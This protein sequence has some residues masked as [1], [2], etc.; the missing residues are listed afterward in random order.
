MSSNL[1]FTRGKNNVSNLI[2]YHSRLDTEWLSTRCL[3]KLRQIHALSIFINPHVPNFPN[4]WRWL[5]KNL[6]VFLNT[7]LSI[8]SSWKNILLS[9]FKQILFQIPRFILVNHVKISTQI[10]TLENYCSCRY[11][12]V[13]MKVQN[14]SNQGYIVI[15]MW[16]LGD[17]YGLL[18][19]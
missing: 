10:F 17:A 9:N 11:E 18:Q 3:S 12:Q 16:Q 1:I 4:Q 15:V 14:I 19:N 2:Q 7:F 13:V 5:N 6:S 8:L